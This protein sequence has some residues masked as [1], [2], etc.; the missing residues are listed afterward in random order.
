MKL[1]RS[2][3]FCIA[4]LIIACSPS[5]PHSPVLVTING[6]KITLADFQKALGLEQWKFGGEVGLTGERLKQFKTKVLETLIKDHL[7]LQEADKRAIPVSNLE[8]EQGVSEFKSYYP[9]QEDFEKLLQLRG[10]TLEDFRTEKMQELKIKK[11]MEAVTKEENPFSEEDLKQ[12][13]AA[14]AE[15]FRHPEQVHAKQIV[16]DTK[17]KAEGLREMLLKGSSFE[18]VA[19]K[20]SLSPD[21]KQGGDLGW[22]GRGV[23]PPE[24]DRVC[25]QLKVGVLSPVIKTPYGFHLF[26]VLETRGAG[27]FPFDEVGEEI[28]KKLMETKGRDVFQKWYEVLRSQAKIEVH[29]ELLDEVK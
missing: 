21:R 26:Q 19:R 29:T 10:W 22:F 9:K 27:Q 18:E 12:Y 16:T 5:K 14:H 1:F 25:F 4:P 15:E 2:I 23:M 6:E 11:L 8:V 17:E 13:Y 24:F 7:L 3:L 28:K 20:Y